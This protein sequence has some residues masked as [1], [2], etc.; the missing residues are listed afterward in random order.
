ML[1]WPASSLLLSAHLSKLR[2][3]PISIQQAAESKEGSPSEGLQVTIGKKLEIRQDPHY[4]GK[5]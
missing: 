3:H 2:F 1:A 5:M 4:A